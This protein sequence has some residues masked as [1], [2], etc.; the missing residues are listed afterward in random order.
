[1]PV[2][3]N[4]FPAN[5]RSLVSSRLIPGTTRKITVRNGPAGDLL[6]WTA[7]QFDARVENIDAESEQFDDWGYAERE[8]RGGTDLSNHASGTA[9][10]LNATRH[11]LASSPSNNFTAKQIA[12][13]HEI[14]AE[15]Q[16]CVRW[17]GD[18]TGRKDPMHFEIVAS[19]E[20][21][22]RALAAVTK[23]DGFLSGLSDA[24]QVDI[25]NRIRQMLRPRFWAMVGGSAQSVPKATKG[26]K[27]TAALDTLD[28][29]F[30]VMR[31]GQLTERVVKLEAQVEQARGKQV[32]AEQVRAAVESELNEFR[33]GWAALNADRDDDTEVPA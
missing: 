22:R 2:S 24:Q 27:P 12:E 29:S 15:A 18:Y 11:P 16:H 23:E 28:G 9:I 5:D 19:E 21:C 26:A 17:G 13:I 3:Q 7:G 10:D 6:L 1:M 33:D 32:T 8:V 20:A 4:G 14:L 25:Y 30:I 31:I